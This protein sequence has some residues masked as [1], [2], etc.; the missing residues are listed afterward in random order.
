MR[1][2]AGQIIKASI[3]V[4]SNDKYEFET[5]VEAEKHNYSDGRG[6]TDEVL[7]YVQGSMWNADHCWISFPSSARYLNAADRSMQPYKHMHD[8]AAAFHSS[9]PPSHK[10]SERDD[11]ARAIPRRRFLRLG[12]TSL[13]KEP[14]IPHLLHLTGHLPASFNMR[15]LTSASPIYW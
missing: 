13:R 15:R 14:E 1:R 9:N 4:I 7:K 5:E 2:D 10:L 6:F 12:T 11:C 3:C 8:S